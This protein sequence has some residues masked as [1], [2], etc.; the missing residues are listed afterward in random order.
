MKE[1]KTK[2]FGGI[3]LQITDLEILKSFKKYTDSES[4]ISIINNSTYQS[5][6]GYKKRPKTSY[7]FNLSN[8]KFF[9]DSLSLGLKARKTF[10]VQF[11][12]KLPIKYY[13]DFLRGVFEGDG[14]VS[15]NERRQS[16]NLTIYCANKQFLIDIDKKILSKKKIISKIHYVPSHN[17]Y[18][19]NISSRNFVDFYDLIYLNVKEDQILKRKRDKFH[20]IVK[21]SK[22]IKNTL[23]KKQINY[24]KL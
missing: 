24:F 2:G 12:F 4:P 8:P 17:L 21:K 22:R 10:T 15:Y 3:V 16:K 14:T 11:P 6:Y 23:T 9:Q 13:G 1:G 5:K 19:L 20:E 18:T 7:M